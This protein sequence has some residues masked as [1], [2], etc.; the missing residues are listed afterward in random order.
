ME[1]EQSKSTEGKV[2]QDSYAQEAAFSENDY[3]H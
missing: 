3:M 2:K 1:R